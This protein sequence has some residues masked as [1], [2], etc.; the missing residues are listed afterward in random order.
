MTRFF[1]CLILVSL[2][3]S[4]ARADA[5]GTVKPTTILKNDPGTLP[6]GARLQLGKLAGFRY[7]RRTPTATMSADGTLLAVVDAGVGVSVVN[8][9]TGKTEHSFPHDFITHCGMAFSADNKMLAVQ[10]Y[11]DL[12]VWDLASRKRLV[13]ARNNPIILS[14]DR[15]PS[16]TPDGKLV[17]FAGIHPSDRRLGEVT[18]YDVASGGPQVIVSCIHNQRLHSALAADGKRMITWGT[19]DAIDFFGSVA[20]KIQVWDLTTGIELRAIKVGARVQGAIFLPDGKTIAAV[21]DQSNVHFLDLATGKT[22]RRLDGGGQPAGDANM[23]LDQDAQRLVIRFRVGGIQAWDLIEGKRLRLADSLQT[24]IQAIAFPDEKSILALGSLGEAVVWWD[25]ADTKAGSFEG[26]RSPIASLSFSADGRT[27]VSASKNRN[28]IVWD[29]ATGKN[30]RRLV[31]GLRLE[32]D[33][34]REI[35]TEGILGSVALNADGTQAALWFLGNNIQ[36]HD[37]KDGKTIRECRVPF[38]ATD[39]FDLHFWADSKRL[40]GAADRNAIVRVW[41]TDTG[42]EIFATPAP[43]NGERS[44]WNSYGTVSPD[45]KLL[46]TMQSDMFSRSPKSTIILWDLATKKEVYRIERA[47]RGDR[48]PA[49]IAFSADSRFLAMHD[50]QGNIE[51][52]RTAGEASPRKLSG[53]ARGTSLQLAY[54]PDG[55]FLAAVGNPGRRRGAVSTTEIPIDVWEVASGHQREQFQG[56]IGEVTCLAFSPDGATLATGSV[57]STVILWDIAGT[58]AKAEPFGK[59]ELAA[60]WKS[61]TRADAN[62]SAT[63]RR[64]IRTPGSVDFLKQNLQ[65]VKKIEYDDAKLARLI[66]DLGNGNF[67]RRDEALRELKVLGERAEDAL[68]AARKKENNLEMNRR[69]DGL[70]DAIANKEMTVDELQALRGVEILE[71]IGSA[72]ARAC[73][74]TLAEGDSFARL[75]RDA[76]AALRRMKQR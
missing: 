50:G 72:E 27:V 38:F 59:N 20:A 25:V 47:Y 33:K 75:T 64:L 56:H 32:M 29:Q 22:V 71:R 31:L 43:P 34:R 52:R 12:V 21:D 18:V 26:H 10:D 16:M 65:P 14:L 60:A 9:K 7:A 30:Q 41:D 58:A 42:R 76:V 67:K 40:T 6:A 45:G 61:L 23:H 11:Q 3:L 48:K 13:K 55:R 5:Q 37:L 4:A 44:Y 66:A 17:S 63:L 2:S 36:L 74:T 35:D 39:L 57:D 28:V 49:G 19:P 15:V 1:R 70:L 51:L 53:A 46:A 62:P 24:Q 8:V 69:I 68:K 54:S 73:L